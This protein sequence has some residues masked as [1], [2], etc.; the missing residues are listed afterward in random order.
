MNFI[1]YIRLKKLV[2][3]MNKAWR[4]GLKPRK[5]MVKVNKSLRNMYQKSWKKAARVSLRSV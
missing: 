3:T 1:K 4:I 2:K 5:T